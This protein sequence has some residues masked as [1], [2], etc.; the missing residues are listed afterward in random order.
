MDLK[1]EELFTI[2]NVQTLVDQLAGLQVRLQTEG[3]NVWTQFLGPLGT[4]GTE[5]Y[6]LK[7]GN[8]SFQLSTHMEQGWVILTGSP[9]SLG[10]RPIL[11]MVVE[12]ENHRLSRCEFNKFLVAA[13]AAFKAA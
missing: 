3:I 10:T 5:H 7:I 12:D 11:A 8:E 2:T 6:G 9:D 13:T 1:T 4:E